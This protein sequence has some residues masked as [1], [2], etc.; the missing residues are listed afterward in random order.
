VRTLLA[1]GAKTDVQNKA[2]ET[3]LIRAARAGQAG[4]VAALIA[5]K[6]DLNATDYTG[7]S[8]LSYA[9]DGHNSR[10]I[11]LLRQAGAKP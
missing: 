4:A 8:A 7:R 11:D 3:A 5:G 6:A 9:A 10:V 1:G 2:G